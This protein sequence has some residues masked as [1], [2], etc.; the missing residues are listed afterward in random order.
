MT[1]LQRIWHRRVPHVLGVYFATGWAFVEVTAFV[2]GRYKLTDNLVDIAFAGLLV[3]L[4]AVVVLAWNRFGRDEGD[5]LT[6]AEVWA[7]VLNVVGGGALLWGVF[8]GAPVGR[9]TTTIEVTDESGE[10]VTREIPRADLL[11]RVVVFNPASDTDAPPAEHEANALT[12]ALA[13]DLAQDRFVLPQRPTLPAHWQRLRSATDD[14]G[15]A[16]RKLMA[17][18]ATDYE[19]QRFVAGRLARRDG[20]LVA[21]LEV[22]SV[23]PARR[24]AVVEA[25]AATP[26][27]L[28]DAL[29][30]KIRKQLDLVAERAGAADDLPACELLTPVDEALAEFAR[31]DQA[32]IRRNDLNA[33]LD[34]LERALDLDPAFAVAGLDLAFAAYPI[35]QGERARAGLDAALRGIDRLL[36][37][38]RFAARAFDAEFRNDAATAERLRELW[39]EL[40]PQDPQAR[41]QLAMH[42]MARGNRLREALV[43]L[44][45]LHRLGRGFDATLLRIGVVRR[46]LGDLD[47]AIAAYEA[48]RA[49]H[50]EQPDPLYALANLHLRQDDAPAAESLLRDATALPAGGPQARLQLA[51]FLVDQGRF[52]ESLRE[53]D[54]AQSESRLLEDT[55]EILRTR[56]SVLRSQGRLREAAALVEQ[57]VATQPN[58]LQAMARLSLGIWLLESSASAEARAP[59]LAA[60]DAVF[61]GDSEI[62]ASMRTQSRWL[63]LLESDDRAGFEAAAAAMVAVI[64]RHQ[65]DDFAYIATFTDARLAELAG[66]T[67]AAARGYAQALEAARATT[68]INQMLGESR[69]LRFTLRAQRLARD[70]VAAEASAADL[71]RLVPGSPEALLERALLARDRGDGVRAAALVDRILAITDGSDPGFGLRLEAQALRTSLGAG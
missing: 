10:R 28:A 40:H 27:A 14:E 29:T 65:R 71:E 2:V 58:A 13:M 61:P 6:R 8:G 38:Q 37:A 68:T 41:E 21:T 62:A 43:Q 16:P 25:R 9:A 45:A 66:D 46:A 39:V 70:W 59:L 54:V 4:P 36:D 47:G 69:M 32:I 24:V 7:L 42:Y 20:M 17:E 56:I 1:W 63:L 22:F 44:E 57:V 64:R 5:R 15:L 48:Y 50:P 60:I 26:C 23:D 34:H 31:S 51:R 3:L 35:G 55:S 12:I 18:I 52:E 67:A 49:Q 33:G 11:R 53:I 19:A 30:P